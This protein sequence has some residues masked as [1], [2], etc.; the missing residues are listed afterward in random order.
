MKTQLFEKLYKYAQ[1]INYYKN[2]QIF[3]SRYVSLIEQIG[4]Q[5]GENGNARRMY[6]TIDK[7]KTKEYEGRKL[8]G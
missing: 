6:M 8:V 5:F 4:L 2:I 1:N 3:L 7:G